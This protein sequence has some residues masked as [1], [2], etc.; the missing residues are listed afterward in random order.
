MPPGP[1]S[2]IAPPP[3]GFAPSKFW[4]SIWLVPS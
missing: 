1:L 3:D 4:T 2:A